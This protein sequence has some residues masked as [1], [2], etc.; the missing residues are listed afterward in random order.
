M[1]PRHIVSS[2]SLMRRVAVHIQY[3]QLVAH[4]LV[5]RG[6]RQRAEVALD[7]G[8]G[9]GEAM[10]SAPSPDR[11]AL[12]AQGELI[13]AREGFGRSQSL[14]RLFR[15]LLACSLE[16]RVPKELEIAD[17]VFGRTAGAH[18]E[19][20]ASIR[21]HVHRLRRKLDDFY[22][23]P[24][25]DEPVRLTIPRGGYRL[26]AEPMGAAVETGEEEAESATGPIRWRRRRSEWA[27]LGALLIA[28]AAATWWLAR[29]ADPTDASLQA[30]QA[31]ALW[32]PVTTGGRR[33]VV[34]VGD[35]YIFGEREPGGGV[36]R[37]V[38]KFDVNSP[39]D[40]ERLTAGD[41]ERSTRYVDLGLN[42]L[43]VGIGNAMRV[44][45]PLL[46]RNAEGPLSAM[47]V[48]T[49]QL[50]PEMVKLT[51]LVYLGYLSALGPLR[52]PTF[53]GARFTVGDSY[54]EIV[55]RR[56]GRSYMGGTHLERG[57]N[58]PTRDYAIIS[59]FTGVSGNRVVV[60]AGTRD[61]ALMQ[62]AEFATRP[63]M[64]DRIARAVGDAPAF[65][66]LLSVDSLDQ[67]GLQAQLVA[68]SPRPREADWSGTVVQ[69]FPDDHVT[70]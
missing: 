32:Q 69:R 44:V 70:R 61:A 42:Y 13:L 33:I 8:L 35:Y 38:R 53:A 59:S 21:V 30:A 37:L 57:G 64:L 56:T 27:I 11:E 48:P 65:E 2:V 66:A 6:E 41:P 67:V 3:L 26:A 18:G 29:R 60:I 17:E 63:E 19:Q 31:S 20:D 52:D 16:G 25:A 5:G 12:R 40:L 24:G 39:A 15:F 7:G 28:V 51:N 46:R 58:S 4:G 10:A 47:V 14:E 43:P 62:A 54:D 49:S 1:P 36:S 22:A 45:A 34:V 55:D 68:A 50:S 9:E 23:G